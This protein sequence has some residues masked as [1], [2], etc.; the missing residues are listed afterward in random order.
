MGNVLGSNESI[1]IKSEGLYKNRF[2]GT[3]R[4]P[5][6]QYVEQ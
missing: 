2:F 6:I 5:E 4:A 1:P 3:T